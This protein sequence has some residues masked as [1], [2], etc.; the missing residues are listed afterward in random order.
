VPLEHEYGSVVGLQSSH[1]RFEAS[2]IVQVEAVAGPVP[3]P[4]VRSV[5]PEQGPDAAFQSPLALQSCSVP[6]EQR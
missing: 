4:Q 2:Q 1:S 3:A 5:V 6:V